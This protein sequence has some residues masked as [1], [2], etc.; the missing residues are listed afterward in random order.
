TRSDLNARSVMVFLD[1]CFSGAERSD[2]EGATIMGK[3]GARGAVI[4]A[5]EAAP[6]GN[7]FVLTAASGNETALPYAEKNH[8]LFT[9]FLLKKIQD[10]KGNVTLKEL[11][12][13]VIKQVSHQSN[14]VNKKPQ[15]PTAVTSGRMTEMWKSKKLVQ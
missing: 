15:T 3:T 9:Y 7:M 4:K 2:R 14:F 10:T 6:K 8:G 1:A 13:Y 12:D 11:S 5:K